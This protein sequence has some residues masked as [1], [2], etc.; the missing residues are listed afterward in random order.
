[1]LSTLPH[2]KNMEEIT[3]FKCYQL[4]FICANVII[5]R[6]ALLPLISEHHF[7]LTHVHK[8]IFSMQLYR[9]PVSILASA[10]VNHPS[11]QRLY[12]GNMTKFA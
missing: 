1:M 9:M 7:V 3:I 10:G 8:H 4:F 5:K 2:L 12:L 6:L 11:Q